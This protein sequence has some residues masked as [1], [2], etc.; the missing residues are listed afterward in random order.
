MVVNSSEVHSV[1]GYGSDPT[2]RLLWFQV[3]VTADGGARGIHANEGLSICPHSWPARVS[4][5]ADSQTNT[6][7]TAHP[8]SHL[9]PPSAPLLHDDLTRLTQ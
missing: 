9:L 6:E 1:D 5:C 2:P 3:R 7:C 8:T 4:P